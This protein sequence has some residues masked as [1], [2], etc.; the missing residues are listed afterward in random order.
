MVHIQ[1]RIFIVPVLH[2]TCTSDKKT[3]L[4]PESDSGNGVLFKKYKNNMNV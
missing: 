4:N 3:N 1:S 2:C